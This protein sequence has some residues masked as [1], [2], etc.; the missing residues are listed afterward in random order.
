MLMEMFYIR[1]GGAVHVWLESP[2]EIN[3][4]Q[5]QLILTATILIVANI[6]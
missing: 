1:W 3:G 6:G 2:S 5:F 4:M